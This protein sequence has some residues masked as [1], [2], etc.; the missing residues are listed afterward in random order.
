MD[1]YVQS[2]RDVIYEEWYD[3]I[4]CVWIVRNC[5]QFF[6]FCINYLRHY[7]KKIKMKGVNKKN[8]RSVFVYLIWYDKKMCIQ[9]F[10][11]ML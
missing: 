2:R 11:I 1:N 7:I 4:L 5:R 6:F 9:L 10:V 3:A 8:S